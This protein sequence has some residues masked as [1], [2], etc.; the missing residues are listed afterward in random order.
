MTKVWTLTVTIIGLLVLL[1]LAGI[2]TGGGDIINFVGLGQSNQFV[3]SGLVI[4]LGVII[5]LVGGVSGI[6]LGF[7]TKN[8]FDYVFLAAFEG[9]LI[10]LAGAFVSIINYAQGFDSWIANLVYIILG[11]LYVS[12]ILAI[13]EFTFNRG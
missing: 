10:Y 5:G 2:P 13:L 3:L 9:T 8:S 7:F 6:I 1:N 12:Y 11:I 4:E